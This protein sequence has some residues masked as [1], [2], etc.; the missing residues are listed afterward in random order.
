[1][2][3]TSAAKSRRGLPKGVYRRG[4]SYWIRVRG[5]DGRLVRHSCGPNLGAAIAERD[6]IV[7]EREVRRRAGPTRLPRLIET[8]LARH[9]LRSRPRTV[10]IS[11]RSAT[12]A[13][14]RSI[15]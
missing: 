7:R 14:K 6:R 3:A 8:W 15:S 4:D 12:L 10:R 1:M 9:E 2:G 13:M 11:A 5:A